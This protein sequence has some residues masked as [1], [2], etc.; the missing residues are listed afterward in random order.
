MAYFKRPPVYTTTNHVLRRLTAAVLLSLFLVG[1]VGGTALA[2]PHRTSYSLGYD[3]GYSTGFKM[4]WKVGLGCN[5][6]DKKDVQVQ[7]QTVPTPSRYDNGYRDGYQSSY[8]DAWDR[9]HYEL[10]EGW[11]DDD[12]CDEYY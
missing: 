9:A 1:L 3:D 12:H 10:T 5:T 7:Q 2:A 11:G 4:G 6:H 8:L